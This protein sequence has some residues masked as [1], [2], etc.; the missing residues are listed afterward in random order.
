MKSAFQTGRHSAADYG[1]QPLALHADV[2]VIGAGA[3]GGAVALA[4][5]EKGLRVIVLE[6]GQHWKPSEFRA[7]QPWALK[8]LYQGR[9]SRA[10]RGNTVMPLPGGRGWAG[11]PSS[12]APLAFGAPKW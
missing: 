1:D 5:A 3:G 6:E 9:G 7:E 2:A 11:P 10:L 4:M 8:N 12:T